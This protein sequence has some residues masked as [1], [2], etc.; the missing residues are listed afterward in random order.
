M[1]RRMVILLSLLILGALILGCAQE[2]KAK[3]TPTP[4]EKKTEEKKTPTPKPTKTATPKPTP[5]KTPTPTPTKT[6]SKVS[7]SPVVECTVCHTK[8]AEYKPH[9]NGGQYCANCHGSNPHTIHVGPGTINLDC[10]ICHGPPDNIQ[11]PKPIEEGR[12]VCENCHAYPDATKPSY[13]NLVNI[14]LPR[15]K[16]CTVCHGTDIP[17]LHK[18]ADSFVE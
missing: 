14:H 18:A 10:S 17:G 3:A 15:G 7:A 9:V 1:K 4:V 5:E 2:E 6:P 16:Y 13:G 12:T 11:I 8:S